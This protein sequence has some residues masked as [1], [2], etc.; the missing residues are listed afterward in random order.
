MILSLSQ[1]LSISSGRGGAARPGPGPARPGSA[2]VRPRSRTAAWLSTALFVALLTGLVAVLFAGLLAVG[3]AAAAQGGAS[4]GTATDTTAGTA[5]ESTASARDA[6][7]QDATALEA[8]L[9]V[10]QT[11]LLVGES[12]RFD[13]SGTTGEV[14]S[15]EYD[16]GSEHASVTEGSSGGHAVSY[17]TAGNYTVLLTVHG[18]YGERD[19]DTVDVTVES[20]DLAVDLEVSDIDPIVGQPVAFEA[21]NATG[22]VTDYR[23]SVTGEDAHGLS[24][25]SGRHTFT[26]PGEY[27][28]AVT[29][30]SADGQE[31][32]TTRNISVASRNESGTLDAAFDVV[33]D[34]ST[35]DE[36]VTL[37]ANASSE[38]IDQYHWAFGDGS[39]AL[40]SDPSTTHEYRQ[41]GTYDVTLTAFGEN[42]TDTTTEEIVVGPPLPPNASVTV[43][44]ENA[45]TADVVEFDAS[46]TTGQVEQFRWQLDDATLRNTTYVESTSHS[47][48]EA[49]TYTVELTAEFADGTTDTA[50]ATVTVDSAEELAANI[51]RT[52]D[53]ATVSEDASLYAFSSTG[54]IGTY[55]WVFG[56]GTTAY[57]TSAATSHAYTAAGN[58]TVELTVFASSGATDTTTLNVTVEPDE[59]GDALHYEYDEP[60]VVGEPAQ[61]SVTEPG[62]LPNSTQH[63]DFGDGTTYVLNGSQPVDHAYHAYDAN[64]TYAV[65]GQIRSDGDLAART[66]ENVTVVAQN[67]SAQ[68][69]AVL[70]VSSESVPAGSSVQLDGS[71][72]TGAIDDYW[73]DVDGHYRPANH[74]TWNQTFDEP[75][76]YNAT[77]VVV[78][79]NA[80]D[81]ATVQIDVRPLASD[82]LVADPVNATVCEPIEFDATGANFDASWYGW[83][84]QEGDVAHGAYSNAGPVVEHA[85]EDPG[86]YTATAWIGDGAGTQLDVKTTVEVSGSSESC[87]ES[88]GGSDDGSE[89][90][91]PGGGLV[92]PQGGDTSS[93]QFD[94]V[95]VDAPSAVE[96]GET[97]DVTVTVDAE[98][99]ETP[100]E[101]ALESE[102]G[103][104]LETD[105]RELTD[106][107]ASF[108]LTAPDSPGS[109]ELGATTLT[110]EHTQSLAVDGA[111]EDASDG[112]AGDASDGVDGDESDD[113]DGEAPG[114]GAT[115]DGSAAGGDGTPGFG[116]AATLVALAGA[117]IALRRPEN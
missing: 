53:G 29:A 86:T 101:I 105:L 38:T 5:A 28:V 92:L 42:A 33:N 47:Y 102:S 97:F 36:H 75:G 103:S 68:I 114:D 93:P 46:A 7:A 71:A 80:T 107:T 95:D 81:E 35:D 26:E 96:P 84:I 57:T 6:A 30:V 87:D 19:W 111:D 78:G 110:D 12:A 54:D 16:V 79:E 113:T 21:T 104:P 56:D 52:E 25:S 48:D 4:A 61:F 9:T 70:D 24:S 40:E 76:T 39:E 109:Y 23:W 72:S 43:E 115:V 60:L 83:L 91:S 20:F 45:T 49:G 64:G 55:R 100:V 67:E 98:D 41:N 11:E 2:I 77:L 117:L 66:T 13:A 22:P 90:D 31:Y 51:T 108:S 88:D 106:G 27:G 15:T 62:D 99:D 14:V 69:E 94:V 8:N 63:W 74:A 58:Y 116:V 50:T 10:E 89:D 1:L 34:G 85:F 18:Q 37:E 32:T 82:P 59:Q 65:E 44:Q 3:G 112:A 73:L 17:E